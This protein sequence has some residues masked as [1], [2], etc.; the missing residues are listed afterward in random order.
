[1]NIYVLQLCCNANIETG[2]Y[3]SQDDKRVASINLH[4]DGDKVGE[5]IYVINI[6]QDQK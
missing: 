1:M 6:H 2:L 3:I 4:Q 5:Y